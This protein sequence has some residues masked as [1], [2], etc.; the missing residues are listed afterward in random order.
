MTWRL[1]YAPCPATPP[2]CSCT[3]E[4]G[5]AVGAAVGARKE[6]ERGKAGAASHIGSGQ[7]YPALDSTS[8]WMTVSAIVS[9]VCEV[10]T[11]SIEGIGCGRRE[12]HVQRVKAD[13]A[14]GG[15]VSKE[16]LR[17]GGVYSGPCFSGHGVSPLWYAAL[18]LGRRRLIGGKLHARGQPCSVQSIQPV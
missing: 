15:W 13:D 1:R 5:V 17:R 10:R 14:D 11:R 3:A 9:G 6:G 4:E 16:K 18:E 12:N 7:T 2:S 8:G